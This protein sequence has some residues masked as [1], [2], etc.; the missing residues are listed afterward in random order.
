MERRQT[1]PRLVHDAIA[2]DEAI[3]CAWCERI[4]VEERDHAPDCPRRKVPAKSRLSS[5]EPTCGGA[6]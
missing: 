3:P 6:L 1:Y 5:P 2:M 4:T